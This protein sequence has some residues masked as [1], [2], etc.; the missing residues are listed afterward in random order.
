MVGFGENFVLRW[1][2]T[3]KCVEYWTTGTS[4]ATVFTFLSMARLYVI[5]NCLQ[6]CLRLAKTPR[7][8]LSILQVLCNVAF[9]IYYIN[10]YILKKLKLMLVLCDVGENSA[11][12]DIWVTIDYH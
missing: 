12:V 5:L 2:L 8:L 10:N 3:Y 6:N 4:A 11:Q 1:T 7:R 9:M